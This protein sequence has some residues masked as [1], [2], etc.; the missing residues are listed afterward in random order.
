MFYT[1]QLQTSWKHS[2]NIKIGK[3]KERNY[4]QNTGNHLKHHERFKIT[5]VIK[6]H[7]RF[8]ITSVIKKNK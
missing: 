6:T 8:K 1:K 2:R 4:F 7:E 5:S 3:N